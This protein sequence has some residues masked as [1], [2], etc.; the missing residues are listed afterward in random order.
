[1]YHYHVG[2]VAK[3]RTAVFQYRTNVDYLSC[4]ILEYYGLRQVT[5]KE[6]K[7]ALNANK[8]AILAQLNISYPKKK[9]TNVIIN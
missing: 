6:A 1:M 2:L 3:K 4:E 5:I 8:S 7:A 9:F